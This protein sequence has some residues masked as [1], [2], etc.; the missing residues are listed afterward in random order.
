MENNLKSN[1]PSISDNNRN[2]LYQVSL[3]QGLSNGDYNGSVSIG[4]LKL[5]GDTGIGTFNKLNGELIML[6]GIVYRASGDGNVEAVLDDET[7]PFCVV[8]F[9]NTDTS[10][11]LTDISDYASLTNELNK[12]VE[13]RGK[14][15]FYMIKIAGTF[16]KINV[17]SVYAQNEPYMP[18]VK[19]LECDQTLFD[20]ENTDGTIVGL[21][22][23]PYMSY[24]NASGWHMHFI[25]KDKTKGGHLLGLNISNAILTWNDIDSFE[26]KLPKSKAFNSFDLSIDQSKDIEKIEKNN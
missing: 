2:T 16:K 11:R 20:Y 6:D 19:V 21:Y 9:L 4:E 5:H 7:S 12:L 22:C 23:P 15:R 26:L 18:L 24:L 25:S 3:L 14:N 10:M 17:R 1:N 13:S 8:T